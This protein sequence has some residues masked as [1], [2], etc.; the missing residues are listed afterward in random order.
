MENGMEDPQKFKDRITVQPSNS[1][2][3]STYKNTK[4]PI[5]QD[6]C[7]SVFIEALFTMAGRDMETT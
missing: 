2:S 4:I 7:I 1:S 3:G 5:Q 6:I